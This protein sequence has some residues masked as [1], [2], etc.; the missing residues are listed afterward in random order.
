MAYDVTKVE[1]W[2]R[3]LDDRA[4]SLA[5]AL[6][7]LAN[8]GV[9]LVFMIARRYSHLPGKG[10]VFV[11]GITGAKATKAAEAAGFKKSTDLAGLRVEGPNKPGD[12]HRVASLLAQAGINLRGVSASV[13]GSKY[14]LIMAFDSAADAD[15]AAAVLKG[16]GKG[17]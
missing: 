2:T 10:V 7:P 14:V 12:A 1:V 5:A 11:G 6:E 13:I 4:G 9:D 15:K 17:K 3:E 16:A 8:A